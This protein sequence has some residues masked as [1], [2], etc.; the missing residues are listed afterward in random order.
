MHFYYIVEETK[1]TVDTSQL[2]GSRAGI[3]NLI[4]KAGTTVE[5][6]TKDIKRN[7]DKW[8]VD[9]FMK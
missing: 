7:E 8:M 9:T 6:E 5:K 2:V 1:A 3:W 4:K